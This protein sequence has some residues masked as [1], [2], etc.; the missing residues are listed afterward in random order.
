MDQSIVRLNDGWIAELSFLFLFQHGDFSPLDA[1]AGEG[2][3]QQAA[4]TPARLA[5]AE[6][7]LDEEVAPILKRHNLE[8]GD[9]IWQIRSFHFGPGV[10]AVGGVA[11][12]DHA[13][14]G[15]AEHLEF[16]V[17]MFQ[18]CR[19]D[20]VEFPRCVDWPDPLPITSE[21]SIV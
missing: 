9:W 11:R 10:A 17:S 12:R 19:L 7:V 4:T 3:V 15:A 18:E 16:S 2:Q 13:F 21:D 6:M 14:L 1:V 5:R 8:A 20:R